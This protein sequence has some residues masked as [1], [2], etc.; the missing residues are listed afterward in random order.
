MTMKT[1]KIYP[2]I[3][4]GGSGT[5]LWPMS[6]EEQ[7][8]Q[9]QSIEG[10]GSMSFFQ[11]TVQ[12]H[13]GGM[14]ATPIVSV[15]E[16]HLET[17][18]RQLAEIQ[19]KAHIITEPMARNTGPAVLAASIYVAGAE[20]ESVIVVLPSDHVIQ[21]D[22]NGIVKSMH[23]AALDGLIVTFGIRPTFAETGYGYIMDGG[24]FDNYPGLHRVER[25]IEKPELSIAHSLFETGSAYWAS[26]I[27]MFRADKLVGEYRL[28][29]PATYDAVQISLNDAQPLS[30]NRGIALSAKG[31]LKALSLPTEKAIF[32]RTKDI[33]L[34]P[35]D[36][37]WD[38]VGAWNSLH[39]IG[40]KCENGNVISG[41]VVMHDTQD[42]LIRG[43]DRLIAVVGMTDVIVVDT[44]DAVL[45]ASKHRSQDVK[46]IV[47]KLVLSKRSEVSTHRNQFME[48][49]TFK[50]IH[51][52]NGV[53]MNLLTIAPGKQARILGG[54][55]R[56]HIVTVLSGT[57]HLKSGA[58]GMPVHAGSAEMFLSADYALVSN[59]SDLPAELIEITCEIKPSIQ[60]LPL[61][62]ISVGALQQ[63][64]GV[65]DYV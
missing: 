33:A 49:G 34:A 62:A 2:L 29:D 57:V 32:E 38:D 54:S 12:R 24:V 27:S 17:A 22:L 56:S 31:F 61:P 3:L 23:K 45:V 19:C 14:F 58:I 50:A 48:W 11:Q 60:Q 30:G 53:T 7:P 52:A 26:G 25:F 36:I 16:R 41:D 59:Y 44:D 28:H 65:E 64:I 55:N 40:R 4:C 10:K 13:R 39:S 37:K 20:P 63:A 9:F 51:T 5:R 15:G 47:E 6:R 21:G 46:K 35:A 1:S 43:G 18:S 8:K 42:S